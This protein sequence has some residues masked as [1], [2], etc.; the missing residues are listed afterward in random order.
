M[1]E[2]AGAAYRAC[3]AWLRLSE[4]TAAFHTVLDTPAFTAN[5]VLVASPSATAHAVY[6]S[7]LPRY[8]A[9]QRRL[10]DG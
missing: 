5:T 9:L 7:M 2:C 1:Y 10:I 3:H 8:A 6:T 4:P